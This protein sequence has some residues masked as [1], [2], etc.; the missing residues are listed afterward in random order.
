MMVH[1]L[2]SCL[3]FFLVA[4]VGCGST[5][6]TGWYL[7]EAVTAPSASA[8]GPSL[9]IV[10]LDVAEYLHAPQI[11]SMNGANRVHRDEFARW[12]EP[13]DEG[14]GRVLSL[15]L[16]AELGSESVRLA[17]WP[18][19]WVPQHELRL[20]LQ[21][22]DAREDRVELV[23]VWSLAAGSGA[24]ESTDR[25]TRL[26]RPRSEVGPA[27]IAADFSALLAELARTI[28]ASIPAGAN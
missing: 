14:V 22:L 18:R 15:D 2:R 24:G 16:A 8:T 11:L 4:L 7:L 23:A 27:G 25:M 3:L 21:A 19:E 17:P 26:S 20:R 13:L 9:G 12:A 5:P 10:S 1:G 28:A 6:R